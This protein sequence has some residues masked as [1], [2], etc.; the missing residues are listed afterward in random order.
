MSISIDAPA[1]LLMLFIYIDF[2][3]TKIVL[4]IL[5]LSKLLII[6]ELG[7]KTWKLWKIIDKNLYIMY[8]KDISANRT[9]KLQEKEIAESCN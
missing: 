2:I 8:K 1:A 6:W 4:P 9:Q 5:I 7:T 3:C